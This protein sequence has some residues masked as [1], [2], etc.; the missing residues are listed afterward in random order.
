MSRA[1]RA[2]YAVAAAE[3]QPA[4]DGER[5]GSDLC[6]VGVGPPVGDVVRDG[7]AEHEVLL[8]HHHHRPAQVGVSSGGPAVN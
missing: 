5:R 3:Q 4:H 7:A 8:R 1:E 6:P 2:F